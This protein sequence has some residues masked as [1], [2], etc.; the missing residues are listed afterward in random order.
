MPRA[1]ECKDCIAEGVT[2]YRATPHGGPRSPLCVTHYRARRKQTR[3][4]AHA[5]RVE[6][7]YGISAVEYWEIYAAQGGKCFVCQ[8]ANGA[9]KRLAVDHDHDVAEHEC[10]HDRD[11]GC[12]NCIRGLLCGPCNELVGKYPVEA[13]LRAVVL[14]TNP[15]AQEVLNG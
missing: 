12:R 13:L 4:R 14:L 9:T 8:R 10:G 5:L 1:P 7:V 15:P 6:K 11:V 2:T 3:A